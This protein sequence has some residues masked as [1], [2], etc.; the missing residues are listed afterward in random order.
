MG[1]T[2][3]TSVLMEWAMTE[4]LNHPMCL[5][6]LQ[7]EVRMICKGRSSVS[8]EDIEDMK[9]LKAV[10]KETLRLHPP[11]PLMAPH[12]STQDGRLGDYQHTCRHTG[13]DQ[14]LCDGYD[15][16]TRCGRV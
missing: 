6:R 9:Y 15:L 5:K 14:R 13:Y 2:D 12:C 11:L 16:G 7:E 3:T 8:E 4:L 1:G 10:T